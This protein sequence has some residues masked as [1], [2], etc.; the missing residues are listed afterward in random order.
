MLCSSTVSRIP[1]RLW[2]WTGR[3][4]SGTSVSISYTTQ[5]VAKTWDCFYSASSQAVKT[6]WA[7]PTLLLPHHVHQ[8]ESLG[9]IQLFT[10]TLFKAV[11]AN[12]K[13]AIKYLV[14]F[15]QL[16][17]RVNMDYEFL[18]VRIKSFKSLL[19]SLNGSKQL[20]CTLLTFIGEIMRVNFHSERISL[21]FVPSC[22]NSY[23]DVSAAQA[24]LTQ[25]KAADP[26]FPFWKNFQNETRSW[27][28]TSLPE[29]QV[30][31]P[32]PEWSLSASS[33]L[34]MASC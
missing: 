24:W 14:M 9:K 25:F 33:V 2:P 19:P 1:Q 22:K 27:K 17:Q 32:Q 31:L 15:L 4:S 7:V 6:T 12:N 21:G 3:P 34:C 20:K 29:V 26:Q 16:S 18:N 11:T 5:A 10:P 23:C 8:R 13:S 30:L 28:L